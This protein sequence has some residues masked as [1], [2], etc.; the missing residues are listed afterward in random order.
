MDKKQTS[1]E[2]TWQTARSNFHGKVL[3]LSTSH[4]I[5]LFSCTEKSVKIYQTIRRHIPYDSKL[6][7]HHRESR[8]SHFLEIYRIAVVLRQLLLL[9]CRADSLHSNL[10]AVCSFVLLRRSVLKMKV[11]IANVLAS[12]RVTGLFWRGRGAYNQEYELHD[13]DVNRANASH[14][15]R[16]YNLFGCGSV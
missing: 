15:W 14:L 12:D 4:S 1:S 5:I 8:I 13:T 6:S 7:T 16:A 3:W 9:Q 10:Q 2:R 11:L